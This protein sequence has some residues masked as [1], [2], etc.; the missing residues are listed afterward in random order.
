MARELPPNE[1][2][3][4]ELS[5][6][7]TWFRNRERPGVVF[8]SCLCLP[9]PSCVSPACAINVRNARSRNES[10]TG[11]TILTMSEYLGYDYDMEDVR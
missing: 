4:Q 11:S 10:R 9:S 5:A 6:S 8:G 3:C 2:P 7:P 1:T